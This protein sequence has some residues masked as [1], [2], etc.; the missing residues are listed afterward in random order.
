MRTVVRK[1]RR[2]GFLPYDPRDL[3]R[4]RGTLPS[5]SRPIGLDVIITS[6]GRALLVEAQC[7]FGRRGLLNLFPAANRAYRKT[8]WALRRELG[9]SPWVSEEL[10]ELCNDKLATY[11]VVGHHQPPSLPYRRYGAG[12]RR[13]LEAQDCERVLL[14][15]ARGCCGN[16]IE[17]LDRQQILRDD[18]LP[19]AAM[20]DMLLQAFVGSRPLAVD[21]RPHLG[22]I[23]HIVILSS[24]GRGLDV[25]HLPSYWRVAPRPLTPA[26]ER[27][28]LTA[29]ISRGAT[30]LAVAPAD[31]QRVH[32]LA[33]QVCHELLCHVTGLSA[34][35]RGTTR[36]IEP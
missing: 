7:G 14:K 35:P 33:E 2:G 22:C 27:E 19:P 16:G 28:A 3:P 15:P 29:N 31:R 12:V 9:K 23:R 32:R 10:R 13:W 6:E 5:F 17:V 21:G 26:P 30:P 18:Q 24:D 4:L 36:V 1:R 25:V 20:G 34:I 11:R 8:Y